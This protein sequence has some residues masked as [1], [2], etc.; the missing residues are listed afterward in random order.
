VGQFDKS[1]QLCETILDKMPQNGEA[2]YRRGCVFAKQRDHNK[3]LECWEK[4]TTSV[5]QNSQILNKISR[6][7]TQL[8]KEE[9]QINSTQIKSNHP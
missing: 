2:H 9:T 8:S 6:K 5:P 1:L 7:K 4:A 3:A